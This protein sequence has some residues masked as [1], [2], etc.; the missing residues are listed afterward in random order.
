VD[1]YLQIFNIKS[2]KSHSWV[3]YLAMLTSDCLWLHQNKIH[4]QHLN[5]YITKATWHIWKLHFIAVSGI[6]IFW[7]N[8]I[9]EQT[10]IF[11][12][13]CHK[14]KWFLRLLP[15]LY[16]LTSVLDMWRNLSGS[17]SCNKH[18]AIKCCSRDYLQICKLAIEISL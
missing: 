12:V 16:L 5:G 4:R 7:P 13:L 11:L 6:V 8:L 2:L 18:L 17:I 3:D 10:C 15:S 14:R 1:L 9:I